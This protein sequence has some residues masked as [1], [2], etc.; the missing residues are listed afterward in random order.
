MESNL[1]ERAVL[2]ARDLFPRGASVLAACSG[3]PDSVALAA[4]LVRCASALGV[5]VVMG[6]V[7][8]A[9][10]PESVRDADQVRALAARLGVSFHLARLE[11]LDIARLGLEAA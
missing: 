6:H 8:H 4:A 3:G 7:D 11:P 9:L 1:T 5:R 2:S 10:R